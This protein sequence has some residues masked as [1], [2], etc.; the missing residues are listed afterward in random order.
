MAEDRRAGELGP[1]VAPDAENA[2]ARS[3]TDEAML[4]RPAA[5]VGA[6]R[7][8]FVDTDSI[9]AWRLRLEAR[10]GVLTGV[11]RTLTSSDLGRISKHCI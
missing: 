2:M 5:A 3:R 6:L 9:S 10:S 8:R 1:T 4:L 7:L 11:L